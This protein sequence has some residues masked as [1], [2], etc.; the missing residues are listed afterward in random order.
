MTKISFMLLKEIND[1]KLYSNVGLQH[2]EEFKMKEAGKGSFRNYLIEDAKNY[3][4]KV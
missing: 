4:R 2:T 3:Q 1:A